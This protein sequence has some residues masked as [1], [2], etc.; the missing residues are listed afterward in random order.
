MRSRMHASRLS[1]LV[2]AIALAPLT[3]CNDGPAPSSAPPAFGSL[4]SAFSTSA[5]RAGVPR[6]LLVAIA[7]VEEG[8]AFPRERSVIDVDNEVP[9]AGPLQLRRG[10]LDT[11]RRGSELANVTELELR[12][13]GDVALEA[14]ALVLAEL[15]SKTGARPDDLA[16]WRSAIEELSG[17]SDAAHRESYTHQVFATLARGGRFAARDGEVIVLK[18]HEVPPSLTIDVSQ[19]VRLQAQAQYPDAEWIPTS[20]TNKCTLTRAGHRV[21][22]IVIH[23]TEGSWNASVATLQNDPDKSVQYIVGTDGRV[24]QFVSEETTAWHAGNFNFN[25]RSV[26]I[27]HIGFATTPF[28]DA[29]YAASAKLVEYL[30]NK[31]DVARDRAH[32][33]GHDQIPNGTKIAAG[34]APCSDSPTQCA[35]NPNYGGASRHSDPGV[36]EWATFMERV[37]GEAKCNDATELWRCG[38]DRAKAFRCAAGKV[39]VQ[40]CGVCETASAASLDDMCNAAPQSTPGGADP[41]LAASDTRAQVDEGCATSRRPSRTEAPAGAVLLAGLVLVRRRARRQR[42]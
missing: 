18:E 38:S 36:W 1:S 20:C 8:L 26:G 22:F 6:D 28:E 16:S 25:Q 23:D 40:T 10:K 14:G 11:L 32:I 24:A 13:H 37:G 33:I 12:A 35:A 4:G 21:E 15:G 5:I 39:A 30:A 31:Y 9:A 41:F 19:R 17:F 2:A 27:E 42:A 34:S 3:S 7:R 29:E